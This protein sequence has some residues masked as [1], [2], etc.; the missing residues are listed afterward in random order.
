METIN[1]GYVLSTLFIRFGGVF[2]V[3][4]ILQVGIISSSKIIHYLELRQSS[5]AGKK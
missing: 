4:A 2:I 3:L 1:W 5:K